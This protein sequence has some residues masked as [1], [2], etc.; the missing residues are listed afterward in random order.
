MVVCLYTGM[1]LADSS[2]FEAVVATIFDIRHLADIQAL[3]Q[4]ASAQQASV[5]P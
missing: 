3:L 2:L 1:L 4:G 5:L